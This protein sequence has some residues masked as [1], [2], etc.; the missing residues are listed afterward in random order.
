M[1]IT[2]RKITKIAME[3]D[4][5]AFRMLKSSG[6]GPGEADVLHTIR[7]RPGITQKEIC[8]YLG[9]DKGAVAREVASM[10]KKGLLVRRTNPFDGRSHLLYATDEAED[11]KRSKTHVETL[12]YSWLLEELTEEEKETFSSL[13]EK[14]YVKCKDERRNNF[15]TMEKIV[16]EDEENENRA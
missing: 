15:S 1:D 8:L 4:K 5:F 2:Q 14:L 12:F 6:L 10:E 16:R 9:F 7:K 13:L 11:L 3:V